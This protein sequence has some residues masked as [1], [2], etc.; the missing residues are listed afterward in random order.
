MQRLNESFG[1]GI[2]ELKSNPYESEILFQSKLKEL[3]FKTIDKLCKVNENYELYF[4]L[5]LGKLDN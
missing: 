5:S 2:V 4:T 1:I 3:D